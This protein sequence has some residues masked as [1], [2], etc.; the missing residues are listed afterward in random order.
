MKVANSRLV[1]GKV[2][3]G[4]LTGGKMDDIT[5]LVSVRV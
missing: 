3:L 1:N 4:Q 2:Q 5:V